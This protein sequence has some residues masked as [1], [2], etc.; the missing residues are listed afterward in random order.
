MY[1]EFLFYYGKCLPCGG[2][3]ERDDINDDDEPLNEVAKKRRKFETESPTQM[4]P[5]P[6]PKSI[7]PEIAQIITDNGIRLEEIKNT[8]KLFHDQNVKIEKRY[9][10]NPKYPSLHLAAE[11][12]QNQSIAG[13][14]RSRVWP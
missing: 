9:K 1:Y 10:P 8:K 7:Y 13:T 12:D 4:F 2:S 14:L 11:N 5:L 3:I 6:I